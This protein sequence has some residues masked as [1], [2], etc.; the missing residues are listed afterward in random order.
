MTEHGVTTNIRLKIEALEVCSR[1]RGWST[2]TEKYSAADVLLP[3][4]AIAVANATRQGLAANRQ[5][6][7]AGHTVVL[8]DQFHPSSCGGI[9]HPDPCGSD[10]HDAWS[11]L[12][13]AHREPS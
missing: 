13:A 3:Y 2:R 5:A 10:A 12:W 11:G 9:V 4:P 8:A 1:A 7:M 6:L